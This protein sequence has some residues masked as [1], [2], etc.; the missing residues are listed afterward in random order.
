MNTHIGFEYLNPEMYSY[1]DLLQ[2]KI[3]QHLKN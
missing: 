3:S 1:T 2:P